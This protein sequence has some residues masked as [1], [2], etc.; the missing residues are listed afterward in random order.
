MKYR[1]LGACAAALLCAA[2]AFAQ[3]LSRVE[4]LALQ[5]QLRDD[6]CG[7]T[8]VTG[9][10]DAMTRSAIRKCQSKYSGATD[11]RSMLAAM[12]IGFGNGQ[13][14]PSL[15]MARSGAT[16]SMSAGGSAGTMRDTTAGMGSG[17]NA[18][19]RR[20]MNGSA[21]KS[22]TMGGRMTDS[23][24]DRMMRRD[25]MRDSTMHPRDTSRTMGSGGT[26]D[27]NKATPMTPPTTTPG[28]NPSMSP[29]NPMNPT[30]N[31][32]NSANPMNPANP[33]NPTPNPMSPTMNPRNS[34]TTGTDTSTMKHDTAA[35]HDTIPKPN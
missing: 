20:G 33:T 7:V 22:G 1:L 28:V 34:S 8:H 17:M 11:A 29:P 16:G 27:M 23:T 32:T 14:A 26:V 15:S 13:Q 24:R 25:R 35:K 3:G 9:R 6:G 12:N 18:R 10:L 4:M 30:P 21:M 19:M 2:P 5:Q 31:P